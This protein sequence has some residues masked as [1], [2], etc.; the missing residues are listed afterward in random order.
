METSDSSDEADMIGSPKRP[1]AAKS[2][3]KVETDD[4]QILSGSV[5]SA[6]YNIFFQVTTYSLRIISRICSKLLSAVF[7]FIFDPPRS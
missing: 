7:P 6:S 1:R 2:A 5:R 4:D 3:F